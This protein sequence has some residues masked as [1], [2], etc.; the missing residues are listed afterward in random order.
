MISADAGVVTGSR[1]T[2]CRTAKPV[3]PALVN[4]ERVTT[5]AQVASARSIWPRARATV[6]LLDTSAGLD[7]IT[8]RYTQMMVFLSRRNGILSKQG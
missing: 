5:Q 2:G 4:A 1:R 6:T 3:Y 7:K 8:Y